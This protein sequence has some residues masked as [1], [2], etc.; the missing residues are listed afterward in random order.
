[1]QCGN[2]TIRVRVGERGREPTTNDVIH[3]QERKKIGFAVVVTTYWEELV[4]SDHNS[5][6]Y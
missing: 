1:M 3:C 2:W 5:N 4:K 6:K